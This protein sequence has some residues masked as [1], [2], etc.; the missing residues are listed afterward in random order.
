ML[1]AG[2]LVGAAFLTKQLQAFLVLPGFAAAYLVAAPV[3][4]LRRLRDGVL[5]VLAMVAAG[6]WWVALVELVPASARPWIGGSQTDS[7]L[8]LT[9]GYNGLGRITGDETGSVG[10]RMGWGATGLGRLVGDEIGGQ[11]AWLLPAAVVLA[12]LTLW[13]TLRRP[14]TDGV[15]AEVV[16]WL[17]WLVVTALTF[18]LMAGIFHAYYTVALA[19]AVA[20]LVGIGSAEAWRRRR[21]VWVAA[22]LAAT[23]LGSAVWAWAL[24]G[25]S[26]EWQPWLR[27]TVLVLGVLATGAVVAAGTSRVRA[28]APLAAGL[29]VTTGLLGPTA[30]TLQTV[31]TPHTGSIVTAGPTVASSFGR[32]GG[33]TPGGAPRAGGQGGG[34]Q[35]QQPPALPG[36]PQNGVS[37]STP[38]GTAQG[39]GGLA[40]GGLA[41]RLGGGTGGLLEGST[42]SQEVV[43]L[44]LQDADSYTW[45]AA[46]VGSNTAAGYQLAT[47]EP[48]MPVG[49]FNGSDPSPTLAEFQ[50]LVA[51]H[52]VHWFVASGG[53]GGQL[54]GS[55]SAREIASWVEETF[56]STTVS[57]AT[58]YDLSSGT[59]AG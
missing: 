31:G 16:V 43:D 13:F 28:L 19:P 10:G 26:A 49:G 9:F 22:V 59:S 25:R 32:P 55:S 4:L 20:A 58:L 15:R 29:A 2:A 40:F 42:P 39:P 17:S 14:R 37:G 47:Q 44:L 11:I 41:G 30:Y 52:E 33:G 6:G 34:R 1:A 56:T 38:P 27:P 8:E 18:S 7:F 53:F 21:T 12:G 35:G 46:A 5:A 51:Q 48:V 36:G 54:G 45:V 3:P 24:L 50:G 23:V 57:G